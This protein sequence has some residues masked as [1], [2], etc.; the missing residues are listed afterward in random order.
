MKRSPWPYA[1]IAYF[2]FF[3]AGVVSFVIWSTR[4]REGLVAENY[5]DQEMVYQGHIDAVKR[6]REE[7]VVPAIAADS[8]A[9]TVRIAFPAPEK[10]TGTSGSI[11]FYRASDETL[12]RTFQMALDAKGA[13]N[14]DVSRLTRGL[15]NVSVRWTNG[16]RDYFA[17]A[18]VYLE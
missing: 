12:D 17:E 13:Q 11:V 5:Y 16:V 1:I 4:H 3:G 6:A 15:W 10:L 18:P 7:G 8:T 2:V 9:R 14:I